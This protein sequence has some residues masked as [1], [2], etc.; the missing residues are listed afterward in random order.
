MKK[1]ILVLY[2]ILAT[3]VLSWCGMNLNLVS[4]PI[5]FNT[6]TFTNPSDDEDTYSS[7]RYNDRIYIPYWTLKWTMNNSEISECIGYI[8]QDWIKI[9]DTKICILNQD[10]QNNYL[11]EIDTVWFMSQPFFLRA[12]DTVWKDI[13]TP[14][15]ID[16][17]DYDFWQ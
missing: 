13:T 16:N 5:E 7:I 10:M 4:N 12:I 6:S 9:E 15:F 3:L 14:E 11:V 8:V 1:G 2:S 17:L